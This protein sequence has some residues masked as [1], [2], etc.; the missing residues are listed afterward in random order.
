[1]GK[2]DINFFNL[3]FENQ[4]HIEAGNTQDFHLDSVLFDLQ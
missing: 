1:M 3:N 4:V 2:K